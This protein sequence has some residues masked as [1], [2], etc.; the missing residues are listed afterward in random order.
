MPGLRRRACSVLIVDDDARNL[1]LARDVLLAAGFRTLVAETGKEAVAL[2]DRASS[3]RDPDGPPAAG[4]GRY[5]RR[6]DPRGGARTAA[7]PVVALSA[8]ALEEDT[9]WLADAG[10]AGYLEKPIDV[11]EF[12]AR[13][14]GSAG[15]ASADAPRPGRRA[16]P[17]VVAPHRFACWH[18]GCAALL[19]TP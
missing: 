8:V 5:G 9:A 11:D 7:I 15:A 1:K 19:L 14:A 10:F 16:N 13:Y 12:P 2:A 3:G 4:H 18:A 17:A 6:Q